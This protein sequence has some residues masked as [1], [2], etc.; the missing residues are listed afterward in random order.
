MLQDA[1]H[2][3]ARRYNL[4]GVA[5]RSIRAESWY[6]AQ[7]GPENCHGARRAWRGFCRPGTSFVS[8]ASVA[9][10]G[11]SEAGNESSYTKFYYGYWRDRGTSYYKSVMG[12]GAK[13]KTMTSPLII[14]SVLYAVF[15]FMILIIKVIIWD[16]IYK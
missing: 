16:T 9:V 13:A 15:L 11:R 10:Q 5:R 14:P 4:V 2:I 3:T 6:P 7:A 8:Y 1:L 12:A